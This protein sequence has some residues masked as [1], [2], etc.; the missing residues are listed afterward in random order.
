MIYYKYIYLV[1]VIGITFSGL[2]LSASNTSTGCTHLETCG[3]GVIQN[4]IIFCKDTC[5]DLTCP[6]VVYCGSPTIVDSTVICEGG[7][8]NQ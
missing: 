5:T 2:T 6:D 1:V 7:F 8:P 4:G 3:Q